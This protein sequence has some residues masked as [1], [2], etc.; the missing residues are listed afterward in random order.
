MGNGSTDGIFPDVNR[1]PLFA[2]G[3][4]SAAGL[5]R[6]NDEPARFYAAQ[7]DIVGLRN[8]EILTFVQNLSPRAGQTWYEGAK[9]VWIMAGRDIVGLGTRLGEYGGVP[10]EIA[11]YQ[12]GL[13]EGGLSSGNLIVHNSPSD[14]SVVSAGRDI[15]YSSFNIAGPGLLEISAGRN[16]LQED[17]ASIASIGP[18]L[19]SQSNDRNSGASIAVI[20]GAGATGPDYAGF[21]ARYLDPSN[22]ADP[23]RALADQ[24]GKVARS[25]EADL[26]A[27]L[28]ERF[29]YEGSAADAL[30]YFSALPAEQQRAFDRYVYF[31]ELHAGGREY[32]DAKGPRFGSYLRGRNAIAALFPAQDETGKPIVYDGDI[33]IFGNAGIQTKFGG[34]IQLLTPGGQQVFGTEGEAPSGVN[35]TPGILTQGSG[36]IQMYSQGS[37]LL[38]QSRIMTTFGGSILAWSAQ[39]D[40]NAGRGSKTTVVYTP[41][42]RIYDSVGNVSLA[43]DVPSTGAGIAT[44]APIPEVPPGRCGSDRARGH[45]RYRRGGGP[46]IGRGQHCRPACGQCRQ[47]PGGRRSRWCA[48][49]GGGQRRRA[50]LG[51]R[52][53]WCGRYRRA[54]HRTALSR[55]VA[56]EPAFHFQRADSGL[57]RRERGRRCGG[58]SNNGDRFGRQWQGGQLPA[59]SNGADCRSR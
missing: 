26:L 42:R 33:T 32:N 47:H 53:V 58:G 21:A 9:P 57:R 6:G 50:D 48:G 23:G 54:R 52:G 25:Y 29:G 39:G 1:F 41:P 5:A 40:I 46:V 13:L 17:R 45:G 24:P 27:W 8:G 37:I 55:R 20:V 7:G 3:A 51:Q 2:F 56:Q 31:A 14:I 19:A 11:N 12:F 22:L 34:D 10:Y 49:A 16:L 59:Q 4:S 35:G 36:N 38:G 43:P 30:A 18:V 28:Q 15:L 44:L